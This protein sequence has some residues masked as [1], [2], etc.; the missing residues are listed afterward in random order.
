[1]IPVG[2]MG[3]PSELKGVALL[4]GSKASSLLTGQTLVIDGG[5]MLAG[6][7]VQN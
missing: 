2:R 5:A 6:P 7:G 3:M 4:L 1:M